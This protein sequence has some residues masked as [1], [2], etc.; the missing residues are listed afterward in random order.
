MKFGENKIAP[1]QKKQNCT[2]IL[3]KL[4]NCWIVVILKN[5]MKILNNSEKFEE[6]L[7]AR[8]EWVSLGKVNLL[9]D[10]I[11]R[12]N[13]FFPRRS[14]EKFPKWNFQL[15]NPNIFEKCVHRVY[16]QL[17]VLMSNS[18]VQ[19]SQSYVQG[20]L[21]Y[22]WKEIMIDQLPISNFPQFSLIFPSNLNF[23]IK[24]NWKTY[25]PKTINEYHL[26]NGD[27]LRWHDFWFSGFCNQKFYLKF[28]FL[29]GGVRGVKNLKIFC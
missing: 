20:H 12:I 7:S 9:F 10:S 8:T 5:F 24:K 4:E 1:S 28:N 2:K 15:Q 14:V 3:R 27:R 16:E 25:T 11:Q 13:I 29:E 21:S 23:Y 19:T 22:S 17:G 26:K 18:I 6:I